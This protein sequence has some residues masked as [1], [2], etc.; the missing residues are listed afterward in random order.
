MKACFEL[1]S[2]ISDLTKKNNRLDSLSENNSKL[3]SSNSKAEQPRKR[4]FN[5]NDISND[6]LLATRTRNFEKRELSIDEYKALLAQ[7]ERNY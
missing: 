4:P 5:D 2:S 6:L 1:S 7:K 3:D